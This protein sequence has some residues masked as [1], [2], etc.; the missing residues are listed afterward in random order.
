MIV[1]AS[2]WGNSFAVRIPA[3]IV[4]TWNLEQGD[5]LTVEFSEN[6]M[7]VKKEKKRRSMK[8]IISDF[9]GMPYEDIAKDPGAVVE[10]DT[11]LDWGE[12]V[13][14]EVIE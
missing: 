12:D 3:N 8:E 13:G 11:E 2:K 10:T 9:Y 14:D 5:N 1:T 7:T 6:V 4:K